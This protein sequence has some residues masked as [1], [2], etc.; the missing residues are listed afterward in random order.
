[1]ATVAKK[2]LVLGF[3]TSSGESL[4]LTINAPKEEMTGTEVA[5]AMDAIIASNAFGEEEV[6]T[7]KANAKYVIQEV[8]ELDLA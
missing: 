2:T 8:E 6:V 4:K 7:S 3:T 5:A 1:M